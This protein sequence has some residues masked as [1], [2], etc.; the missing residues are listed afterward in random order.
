MKKFLLISIA[1]LLALVIGGFLFIHFYI[2]GERVSQLINEQLDNQFEVAII[3]ASPKI[4]SRSIK[5]EG[6]LVEVTGDEAEERIFEADAIE[7][8]GLKLRKLF[9][10][11]MVLKSVNIENYFVDLTKLPNGDD[12]DK[13]DEEPSDF[14]FLTNSLNFAGG[15]IHFPA[16][17]GFGEMSG[18]DLRTGKMNYRP[19]CTDCEDPF[20]ADEIHIKLS[21]V[22]FSF[23]DERYRF[24]GT[25][26]LISETDS[27]FEAA[28]LSLNPVLNEELFFQSLEYRT[29]MFRVNL[30]GFALNQFD[31]NGLIHSDRLKAAYVSADSLDLHVSLDKRVPEDPDSVN[32]PLP[33]DALNNLPIS[34][35]MD[36]VRVHHA[37][38]RY[39]EYDE[40]G[41][42]PGTILF[43]ATNAIISP[44]KSN[45][46]SPMVLNAF[47]LLEGSGELNVTIKLRM[48]NG[49]SVTDVKGS[50][51]AFDVTNL[52]N[53]LNDL[54]G[55]NIDS[56]T[57]REISFEYTMREERA[58]GWI[59]VH[60]DDLSMELIDRDDHDQGFRDRIGSFLMDQIAVREDSRNNGEDFRRGEISEEREPEKGFFNYLWIS[61]R[62][63]IMDA[64]RRI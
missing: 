55:I 16:A 36:S 60:Y 28:N 34:V 2:N 10:G 33:L 46:E 13:Q 59:D 24:E 47:S 52:N 37:D 20:I 51:G 26:I 57:I 25:S 23:W 64:V 29:D 22:W 53:I 5:L 61:L 14:T 12:T 9:R 42:R 30:S 11:E 6:V 8:N 31:L 62:S 32:P 54:E 15:E 21:E 38:I 19:G 49:T 18:L 58:E 4:F 41:V 43:A 27:L 3:K 35:D 39:S 63:G 48:E 17:D 50:L 44:V 40:K 56:G 45:D 1:L 7:L